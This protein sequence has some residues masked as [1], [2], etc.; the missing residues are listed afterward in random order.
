VWA[1]ALP[2]PPN[3]PPTILFSFQDFSARKNQQTFQRIETDR[4]TDFQGKGF[5]QTSH[6]SEQLPKGN[7]EDFLTDKFFYSLTINFI[8]NKKTHRK[9]QAVEN[10]TKNCCVKHMC[11]NSG[12]IS[13]S[14]NSP[15]MSGLVSDI[16]V[17]LLE[18]PRSTGEGGGREGFS[19]LNTKPDTAGQ[20]CHCP[21]IQCTSQG[22]KIYSS[23]WMR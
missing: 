14:P 23:D 22:F 2:P 4:Q 20:P 18:V 19:G 5:S 16:P 8:N 21:S 10:N 17:S 12:Q 13:V 11:R 6:D 1:V 7:K 9:V 15:T 3:P